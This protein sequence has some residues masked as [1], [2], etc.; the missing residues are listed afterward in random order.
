MSNID[1]AKEV[2]LSPSPCL[3]RVQFLEEGLEQELPSLAIIGMGL[4]INFPLLL[5]LQGPSAMMPAL[6]PIKAFRND[7]F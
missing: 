3:R 5:A 1:V 6:C 4:C 7:S 2:G